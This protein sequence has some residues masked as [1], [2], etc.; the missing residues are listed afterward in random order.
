MMDL[1][2]DTEATT[3][4][5]G[6]SSNP[7]AD[8]YLSFGVLVAAGSG[9]RRMEIAAAVVVAGYQLSKATIN[10][11]IMPALRASLALRGINGA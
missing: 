6:I 7:D 9:A 4:Q 1:T 5:D 2:A 11:N 8:N 10:A 3:E